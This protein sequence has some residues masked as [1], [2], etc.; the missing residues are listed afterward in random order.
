MAVGN[1][2]LI[3]TESARWEIPTGACY[4]IVL[5]ELDDDGRYSLGS[6]VDSRVFISF[7]PHQ[8]TVT[9]VQISQ[10]IIDTVTC[11]TEPNPRS[12]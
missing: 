3:S 2:R 4:V 8:T 9:P 1:Q 11:S 6:L 12:G 5:D 7:L 10:Y